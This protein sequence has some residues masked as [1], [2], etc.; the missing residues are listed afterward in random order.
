MSNVAARL[1]SEGYIL[2][3]SEEVVQ[4]MY[5]DLIGFQYLGTSFPARLRVYLGHKA[6]E[7]NLRNSCL[8][9]VHEEPKGR[10]DMG[11]IKIFRLEV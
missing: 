9:Y 1:K 3:D 5:Q 2:D 6:K 8:I 11:W 10:Q 7:L 4:G